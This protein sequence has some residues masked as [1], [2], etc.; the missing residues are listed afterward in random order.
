MDINT[1]ISDIKSLKIQGAEGV[2]LA[3]VDAIE[4]AN[5]KPKARDIKSFYSGLLAA[6]RQL[7]ACRPIEPCL[8]NTLNFL[9]HNLNITDVSH[10]HSHLDIRIHAA[11]QHFTDSSKRIVEYASKKIANGMVVYTH[12]HSSTVMGVL[13]SAKKQGKEFTVHNTETRPVL[14]GRKT[15]K[16]LSAAGIRVKHYIDSALRLALKRADIV[17]LGADAITSEGKVIN[18]IGSEL[19]A[20]VAHNYDIPVYVCTNSWK[21]DPKT[22]FGFDEP[23]EN[24]GREEVWA[25]AP[26]NV[27]IMNPAF[28]IVKPELVSS[29]ISELGLYKPEMFIEEVRHKYPWIFK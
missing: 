4:I 29:I 24:R 21:F 6:K 23:I 20:E 9:L 16:E 14:Q 12:C 18:K 15:A 25:D 8:S 28:E 7:V 19:I 3:A 10:M 5:H 2:A 17:L 27:T 26:K 22:V 11:R 13:I 1:I